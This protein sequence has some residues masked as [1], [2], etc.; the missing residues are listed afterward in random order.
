MISYA[1]AHTSKFTI[2]NHITGIQPYL[3]QFQTMFMP[4]HT[5]KVVQRISCAHNRLKPL[6]FNFRSVKLLSHM[7]QVVE[8][9]RVYCAAHVVLLCCSRMQNCF[10]NV[11]LREVGVERTVA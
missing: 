7:L 9:L 6:G 1:L 2:F 3:V 8:L 5:R 10:I 11:A 4:F